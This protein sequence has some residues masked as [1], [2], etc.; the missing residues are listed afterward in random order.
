MARRTKTSFF[1]ALERLDEPGDTEDEEDSLEMRLARSRSHKS[2]PRVN[3]ATSPLVS[4]EPA[5]LR[6]VNTEPQPSSTDS[7]IRITGVSYNAHPRRTVA[8]VASAEPKVRTVRRAQ[9]TGTMPG[10][11]SGG[12][13]AAKRRR[14]ESI[15][16]VPPEQQIF[17][18]LVFCKALPAW[19]ASS[20]C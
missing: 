13:P 20:P 8:S 11:K 1:A 14:V 9:T 6:R 18:E 17:K 16:T 2:P 3:T 19:S 10:T 12:G 7:D 4:A 15:K 5:S